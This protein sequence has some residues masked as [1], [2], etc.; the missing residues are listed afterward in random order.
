MIPIKFN[1]LDELATNHYDYLC[2]KLNFS[3]KKRINSSKNKFKHEKGNIYEEYYILLEYLDENLKDIILGK[4]SILEFHK[5]ELLKK[6]K[7]FDFAKKK[8]D[9][10]QE[11]NEI[12]EDLNSI[13]NYT[14][15]SF[16][17]FS[18]T[19][20]KKKVSY[21]GYDFIQN[22]NI[23]TC[24]YC[25]RNTIYNLNK[26]NKRTSEL[27]HF[28]PKS[29]Y[30]YFALSFY[31]LVPSCKVCNKLK[32]DKDER[33][34]INPYD[35]RFNFHKSI[36]FKLKIK[37][38]TFYYSKDGFSISF[39][40][41]NNV[42]LDEKKRIV[43]SIKLFELKDLYENHKDTI[44]ELI[45]KSQVYTDTYINELFKQYEGTLFNN[46]ED[47]IRLITCGYMNDEDLN[48]RPLSKLIKDISENLKLY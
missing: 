35:H 32:L 43:N 14:C 20:K 18:K 31:N 26:S 17:G 19:T 29:K 42:K 25:N 40:F 11:Q 36:K 33:K 22:L 10:K 2:N 27:D 4:P 44:L 8:E 48:N 9:K 39:S 23:N 6:S 7:S 5:L 34:Y 15:F 37:D 12:L 24:V 30:P 41:N 38:S 45:Q 28:Y 46:R 3:I 13:F 47:L 1:T 21:S 16:P